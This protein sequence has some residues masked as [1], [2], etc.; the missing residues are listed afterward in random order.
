MNLVDP[1]YYPKKT[2][3]PEQESDYFITTFGHKHSNLFHFWNHQTKTSAY[4]IKTIVDIFYNY[5]CK[6]G[7]K[8]YTKSGITI[9]VTKGAL[10][11]KG[12]LLF[13]IKDRCLEYYSWENSGYIC[14][15][16]DA[17]KNAGIL[18]RVPQY[19]EL[20]R[21]YIDPRIPRYRF[22]DL[23]ERDEFMLKASQEFIK[24]RFNTV[25]LKH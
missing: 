5:D 2:K 20:N 6:Y 24:S 1:Q 23:D 13:F 7:V 16:Y 17:I 14:N 12:R 10:F 19:E 21:L 18:R 8:M 11:V 3:F 22:D 15:V 9:W 25:F 4:N